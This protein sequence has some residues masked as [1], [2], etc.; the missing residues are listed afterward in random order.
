LYQP[1]AISPAFVSS[2]KNPFAI[3]IQA[4]IAAITW[5]GTFAAAGITAVV[6]GQVVQSGAHQTSIEWIVDG[7]A[8]WVAIDSTVLER[9][10]QLNS[11]LATKMR[12]IAGIG[13]SSMPPLVAAQHLAHSV[14]TYNPIVL[15]M[16]G[17]Y[18]PHV[19]EPA[20]TRLVTI[21]LL[22]NI[23]LTALELLD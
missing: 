3:T 5:C 17:F 4:P 6:L 11:D 10:L 20:P 13:P 8:D 15:A 23:K 21:A 16:K 7:L 14:M 18:P 1:I 22:V 12:V 19:T 9:A 2:L